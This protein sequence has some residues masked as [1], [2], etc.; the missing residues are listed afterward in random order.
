M[1]W[2][3]LLF[4]L[5]ATRLLGQP[6]RGDEFSQQDAGL[7][8]RE[9]VDG[10]VVGLQIH[11]TE[12]HA[13]AS[14][15][16]TA[17]IEFFFDT[18]LVARIRIIKID[19]YDPGSGE[20]DSAMV[21]STD[22]DGTLTEGFRVLSTGGVQLDIGQTFGLGTGLC[23]GDCDTEIF[24]DID[25]RL[26][27]NFG[28][29]DRYRWDSGNF[30][31][32]DT[33]GFRLRRSE[34]TAAQP[35]YAFQ[36]GTNLGM[37]RIGA[38]NLGFSV[39]S[40]KFFELG[41]SQTSLCQDTTATTGDTLCVVKAGAGEAGNLQEW[42]NNSGTVLASIDLDGNLILDDSTGDSPQAQFVPATG[43]QFNIFVEDTTDDARFTVNTASTENA[44]F[45]NIGVGILE[46]F[47][48]T[49]D[50]VLTS[51]R[52]GA[53]IVTGTVDEARLDANVVLDNAANT[54]GA[55]AQDFSSASMTL[56][57]SQTLTTPTI[58]GTG[59]TNAQ[60]A[61]LGATSGGLLTAPA[62]PNSIRDMK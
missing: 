11:N 62:L 48:E 56:P 54:Y 30:N 60:H 2:L 28:G 24:E 39:G 61:H 27:F 9:A 31:S 12:P 20:D 21:F 37:Y 59:F 19:D 41:G 8:S 46:V 52:D 15:N 3:L 4:F 18:D 5:S 7:D 17:D 14:T 1:R 58:S 35:A 53:H 25:D 13:A 10:S 34:G 50:G 49:A 47:I 26:T 22:R 44:E 29:S 43:T 33:G 32:L 42:Q 51:L 55:F 36:G 40:V 23:F 16:E 38:D 45:E 57:T 6:V